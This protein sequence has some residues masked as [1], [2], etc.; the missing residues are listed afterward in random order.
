MCSCVGDV[1]TYI[2]TCT[3]TKQLWRMLRCWCGASTPQATTCCPAGPSMALVFSRLSTDGHSLISWVLLQHYPAATC[4]QGGVKVVPPSGRHHYCLVEA[5]VGQAQRHSAAP[6]G[7]GLL[8][9]AGRG[10]DDTS[11]QTQGWRHSERRHHGGGAV[12]CR[13]R[14]RCRAGGRSAGEGR[15]PPAQFSVSRGTASPRRPSQCC[16]LVARSGGSHV[17]WAGAG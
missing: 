10:Q 11:R 1:H 14:R 9:P 13:V 16:L 4:R 7:Q 8:A 6:G 3:H 5:V 2:H 12:C 17:A 15:G